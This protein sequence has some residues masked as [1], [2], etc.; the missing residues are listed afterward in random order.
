LSPKFR[1]DR[2]EAMSTQFLNEDLKE[3]AIGL[4]RRVAGSREVVAACFYG[5]RVCGYADEKS[6]VNV[7]LVLRDYRPGLK[8]HVTTLNE[9]DAFLLVADCGAFERDVE[10]GLLGEFIAEKITVPY[11]PLINEGYLRGQEVRMKKRVVW[12]LLENIV[13]E[14][15]ELSHELLIK[16]EYFLYEAMTRRARL[17]PPITYSFLNMLRRDVRKRNVES[18]MEGYLK[19]LDELA[20]ENWVTFSNGY[21]K[22][23]RKFIDAVRSRRLRVPIFLK[24]I[25]RAVFLHV[26]GVFPKMTTPLIHDEEIFIKSHRGVE[27]EE[28][29]FQ[30]EDPKKHLLISTP[31][32]FATLSDKTTIEDF[33]RKTVPGGEALDMEIKEIGGVLN[34][35]YL[36]TF[37][38]NHEKQRVVVKK[39]KDWLGFKWFPL[40]LWALGTQAFAV[41]GRSR[42][43]REYAVHQFLHGQGFPVPRVLY[44]SPKEGLIFEDFVEGENLVGVIK[45]VIS[46]KQEAAKETALVRG[47][48]RIIAEAHRVGVALGDCKPEN[49]IVTKDGKIWLVDL[50]QATRNGNQAWDVAEFLYYSG[51]YVSPLSPADAAELIAKEFIEGYL[52]VGGSKETVRKAGSPRY[53]KVFSLFTPPHVI[54]AVSNLCKKLEGG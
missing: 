53:T 35:V 30:L 54:L 3:N 13:L 27:V 6:N 49:F 47:V 50:E 11:E 32:G 9:V 39:F 33:V 37:Q 24:S 17:F 48:G 43:D 31:L 23:N 4:C 45:R 12:E 46:F 28:L 18:M 15:P 5:P 38:K 21:F 16:A 26:L 22:I 1:V 41:L 52:E 2:E 8:C 42:L 44:V 34:A 51:H 14:F 25:Q 20:D 10:Q 40:A 36:L 29:I 7:L 19:A